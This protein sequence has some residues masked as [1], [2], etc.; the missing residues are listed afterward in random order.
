[1]RYVSILLFFVLLGTPA[2][3]SA[4]LATDISG[5]TGTLAVTLNPTYPAPRRNSHCPPSTT[6]LWVPRLAPSRG[7]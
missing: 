2:F 6:M 7:I 1:M 5:L 4:Q 3:S